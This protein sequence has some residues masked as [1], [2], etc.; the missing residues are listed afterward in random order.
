MGIFLNSG[1]PIIAEQLSFSGYDWLL[2]DIQHS[3]YNFQNLSHMLSG[4]NN[5]KALSMV[6]VGGYEDRYG[7]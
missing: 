3:P 4:I 1:S 5:G 7:I 6:R 2:V